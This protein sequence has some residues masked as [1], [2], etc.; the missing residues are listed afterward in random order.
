[1]GE[2]PSTGGCPPVEFPP[3]EAGAT[4]SQPATDRT[5]I[6]EVDD[7]YPW[8]KGDG[9]RA[10]CDAQCQLIEQGRTKTELGR[11]VG[12]RER[13]DT[14]ESSPRVV[15]RSKECAASK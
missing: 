11:Q 2:P 12:R 10:R 13:S 8:F 14:T 15:Q 5:I 7:G 3:V 9:R 6:V 1:M 4:I